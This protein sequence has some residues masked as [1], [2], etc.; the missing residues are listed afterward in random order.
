[1]HGSGRRPLPTRCWQLEQE[2]D[3]LREQQK[4][5]EQEARESLCST[6]SDFSRVTSSSRSALPD[7]A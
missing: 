7:S 1:M 2:R 4:A 5:L 6:P 3:Q